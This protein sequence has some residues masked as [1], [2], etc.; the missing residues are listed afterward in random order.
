M[1]ARKDHKHMTVE[2][3]NGKQEIHYLKTDNP[4]TQQKTHQYIMHHDKVIFSSPDKISIQ[5]LWNNITGKNFKKD[6]EHNQYLEMMKGESG[7]VSGYI[8]LYLKAGVMKDEY[9]VPESTVLDTVKKGYTN[10]GHSILFGSATKFGDIFIKDKNGD[11]SYD[12]PGKFNLTKQGLEAAQ[13]WHCV[14][15]G[16]TFHFDVQNIENGFTIIRIKA[17]QIIASTT[18]AIIET[19]SIPKEQSLEDNETEKEL[20][21]KEVFSLCKITDSAPYIMSLPY[22]ELPRK[23]YTDVKSIIEKNGGRWK[24]GKTQGF[25]F[26]FNPTELFSKL[27]SG[28]DVNN[29]KEFQFFATPNEVI[30]L[31]ITKADLKASD[32]VLE[33]SA[34]KG[35]IVDRILPLCKKVYM[36][37]LM[38]ENRQIL[39]KKG[40]KDLIV[41]EDF[42]TLDEKKY[43]YDKIIA[44]PPFTKNKDCLHILKMYEHLKSKG[45]LVS[46]MGPS[47]VT[48]TQKKQIEFRNC[49]TKLGASWESI[50]E[51][52]FKKSGTNVKTYLVVIDKK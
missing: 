36:C 3:K 19:A 33:P 15:W 23:V 38:Q 48:G 46:I 24:G 7:L 22:I 47:W 21:A 29:K 11:Y 26:E 2:M 16:N 18:F 14:Q 8:Q 51:G 35:N 49:L 41:S 6:G 39:E 50:E 1:I 25:Q 13:D 9:L 20:T 45:R 37:E 28:E 10:G 44:N 31:M 43:K 4:Y 34:G 17:D 27:H 40:Y 42:T 12:L 32:V 30:N 5:L 52:A